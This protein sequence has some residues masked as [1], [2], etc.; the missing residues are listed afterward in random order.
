MVH[1]TD[2]GIFDAPVDKVWKY[3]NDQN[4]HEHSGVRF[5][6]VLEQSSKGMTAEL[7]VKNPTEVGTR[8]LGR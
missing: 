7:E 3:L 1:I 2:D 6:K 8:K 5:T 4:G